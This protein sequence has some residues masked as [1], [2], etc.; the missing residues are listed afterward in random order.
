MDH[1]DG[2]LI[3][4]RIPKDQRKEALRI[5]REGADAL[6]PRSMSGDDKSR[7]GDRVAAG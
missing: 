1:L 3:I 6:E 7:Q 4:D 2:V 5:L